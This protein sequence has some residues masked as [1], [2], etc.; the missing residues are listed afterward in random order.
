MVKIELL[1]TKRTKAFI[2]SILLLLIGVLWVFGASQ[3]KSIIPL[4]LD[5]EALPRI[6][7]LF[8]SLNG[9]L[10][11][12][13]IGLFASKI[14][15]IEHMGNNFKLILTSNQ[16]LKDL[17]TAKVILSNLFFTFLIL[18]QILSIVGISI[19]MKIKIDSQI[20]LYYFLS[21]TIA[22]FILILIQVFLSLR[23]EKQSVGIG[24]SLIGAFLSLTLYRS[25]QFI[26]SIVPWC[27]YNKLSPVK[28][29][30]IEGVAHYFKITGAL[31]IYLIYSVVYIVFFFMVRS[32]YKKTN[33]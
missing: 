3:Q 28:M 4:D 6:I 12:V 31:N 2:I 5:I 20:L 24:A 7:E 18:L 15:N 23:F 19:I 17:F 9:L 26:K 14:S 32:I 13:A 11:S 33:Y 8:A 1:K 27:F 16:N 21:S 22:S 29:V 10:F 30:G 25:P